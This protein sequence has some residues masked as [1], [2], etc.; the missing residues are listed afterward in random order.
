MRRGQKTSA[1]QIVLKLRHIE[2][3]TDQGK[4]LALACR[5]VKISERSYYRW[6]K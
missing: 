3:Q 1:E 5:E 2:V 4:N 6:R